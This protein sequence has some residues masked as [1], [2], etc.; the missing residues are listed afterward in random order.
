[1]SNN[2]KHTLTHSFLFPILKNNI[3]QLSTDKIINSF[4][5]DLTIPK[6]QYYF[7]EGKILNQHLV[8]VHSNSQDVDFLKWETDIQNNELFVTSY[9]I[10]NTRQGVKVFKFPT[11]F[12]QDY[13]Y[14]LNGEYSKFTE[15]S[16]NIIINHHRNISKKEFVRQTL[17]K[18]ESLRRS[19]KTSDDID[20]PIEQEYFYKPVLQYKSEIP[21]PTGEVLTE[22]IKSKL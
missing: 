13:H 11:D 19:W 18:E 16:K 12:E 6:Y 2:F 10:N 1:M 15:R 14:F 7:S 4:L 8:L 3:T 20:I 22:L 21:Y 5:Y 9:D 17:L